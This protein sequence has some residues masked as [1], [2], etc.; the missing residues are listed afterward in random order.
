MKEK[1]FK[2]NESIKSVIELMD[3]RT[4]GKFIKSV[5]NYAFYGDVY[6]GNNVTIKS[7]FALV[8]RILDG[9]ARDR[10]YG[11]IGAEKSKEMRKQREAET[12]MKQAVIS[13]AITSGIGKVLSKSNDK[14]ETGDK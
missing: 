9:Q 10:A 5:C 13:C 6:D 4:A 7:N 8:K 11:L 2:V 1:Y 14:N 12:A 3:D